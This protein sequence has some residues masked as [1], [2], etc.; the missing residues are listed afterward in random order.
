M[1]SY[2]IK[3]KLLIPNLPFSGKNVTDCDKKKIKQN[4][5][6][7]PLSFQVKC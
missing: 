5:N 1:E 7:V 4:D 6:T 3:L 2:L